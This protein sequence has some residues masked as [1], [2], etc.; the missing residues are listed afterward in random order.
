MYF[1]RKAQET[2]RMRPQKELSPSFW[3]SEGVSA[4]DSDGFDTILTGIEHQLGRLLYSTSDVASA[5]KIFVGLFR[6][7]PGTP[8]FSPPPVIDGKGYP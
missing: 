2:Y 4:S 7:S 8:L 3:D 6:G 5:V 1:L